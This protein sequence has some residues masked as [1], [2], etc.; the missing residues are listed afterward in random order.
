MPPQFLLLQVVVTEGASDR[1][2]SSRALHLEC[3]QPSSVSGR[4]Q[5]R[6][7]GAAVGEGDHTV[8]A[9]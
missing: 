5:L 7:E 3:E 8:H 4:A 9:Y 6:S 2:F 1:A